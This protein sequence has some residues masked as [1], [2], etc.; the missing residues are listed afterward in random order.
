MTW[1]R[2]Q[3]VSA[4]LQ[5]IRRADDETFIRA[6]RERNE[7]AIRNSATGRWLQEALR[8]LAGK[9]RETKGATP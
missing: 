6:A 3:P 4:G 5:A 9:R 2:R 7:N 1:Y 8:R